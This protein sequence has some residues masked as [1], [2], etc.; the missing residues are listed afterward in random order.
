MS[1]HN[2]RR[3]LQLLSTAAF[4]TLFAGSASAIGTPSVE[5]IRYHIEHGVDAGFGYSGLHD[6][7]DDTPMSG[8][9]VADLNGTLTFDY[10][11]AAD[12][13]TLV[14]SDV[15]ANSGIDFAIVSGEITGD[16]AGFLEYVLSGTTSYASTGRI[17][18]TGGA[19]VCCGEGGP[20]YITRDQRRLWG[21]SDV[22]Q[23]N[24]RIGM[25]LGGSA[26]P[27]PEPSSAL[28]FTLGGV[29]LYARQ[30]GA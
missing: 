6:A 15:Y 19:S 27:L 11:S 28:L 26:V 10:D 22:G 24:G 9:Q 20:N 30:R 29:L 2:A 17:V 25:D 14:S 8:A 5:R 3:L 16:G 23:G 13:Y 12:L 4:L 1:S 18:Y 21:A 7:D